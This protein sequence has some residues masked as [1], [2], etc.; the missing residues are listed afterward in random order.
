MQKL[1]LPTIIGPTVLDCNLRPKKINYPV[2]IAVQDGMQV[3][4]RFFERQQTK[5][6]SLTEFLFSWDLTPLALAPHLGL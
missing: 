3:P 2:D 6:E 5:S 1:R 4:V